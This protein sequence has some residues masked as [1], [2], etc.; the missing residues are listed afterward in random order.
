MFI[1]SVRP[2]KVNATFVVVSENARSTS[3]V[4]SF[5]S[6]WFLVSQGLGHGDGNGTQLPSQ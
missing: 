3:H 1:G 4:E 5:L 6:D 2:A